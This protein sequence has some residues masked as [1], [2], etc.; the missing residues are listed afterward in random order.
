MAD[1]AEEKLA[2]TIAF[3]PQIP[4]KITDEDVIKA[5]SNMPEIFRQAVVL[6]DIEEFSYKEIASIL[7]L[8]MG[9]VMSRISRGRKV[10]RMEL[11]DYA[12][13]YGFGENQKLAAG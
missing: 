3:E 10:L 7:S 2:E 13:N 8:P 4:Q 11:A 5:L 1:D 6:S 9:T 12:R